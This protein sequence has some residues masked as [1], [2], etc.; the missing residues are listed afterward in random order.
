MSDCRK[1]G[2]VSEEEKSPEDRLLLLEKVWPTV[3]EKIQSYDCVLSGFSQL[4]D[5]IDLIYQELNAIYSKNKNSSEYL[6]AWKK[7]HEQKN[8]EV[9]SFISECKKNID[10][11]NCLSTDVNEKINSLSTKTSSNIDDLSN[12]HKDIESKVCLKSEVN[13]FKLYIDSKFDSLMD[14]VTINRNLSI[15]TC[16]VNAD[17]IMSQDEIIL[18]LSNEVLEIDA[19]L[20]RIDILEKSI[21]A[22]LLSLN[23]IKSSQKAQIDLLVDQKIEEFKSKNDQLPDVLRNEFMKKL[24]GVAL[25]GSNAVLKANN[26]SQQ[27]FILEK[28]IENIYLQIKKLELAK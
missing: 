22:I 21:T 9:L 11:L 27:I 12:K 15:D 19:H 25:D 14:L 4:K 1:F 8:I 26:S 16:K 13:A 7:S 3:V 17:K 6:D 20:S 10:N 5:R 18:K 2:Q 23:D 28:K 24:E